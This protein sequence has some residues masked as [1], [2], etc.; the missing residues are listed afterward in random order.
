MIGKFKA[1]AFYMYKKYEVSLCCIELSKVLH[2][3]SIFNT[4]THEQCQQRQQLKVIIKLIYINSCY[5][6]MFLNTNLEIYETVGKMV[7]HYGMPF[8]LERNVSVVLR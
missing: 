7:E 4:I 8:L 3:L 2:E 1:R 5:L 6:K